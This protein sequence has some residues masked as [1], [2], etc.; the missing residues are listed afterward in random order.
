MTIKRATTAL[1]AVT[2]LAHPA[3][4]ETVLTFTTYEPETYSVI[5]C[6]GWFMEEV[7]KRTDGEVTFETFYSA[8]L[9]GPADT[10]PGVGRGAADIGMSYP[11]AYNRAEYPLSN[12]V[13][14]YVTANP[15]AATLAYNDLLQ[16]NEAFQEEYARG[17]TKILYSTV[18]IGHSLWSRDPIRT[19]DDV[20]G[21]R[22]RAVLAVGDALDKMGATVVALPFADAIQAMNNGAIDAMG[23]TPFD[24]A[25]TAGIHQVSNYATDLGGMGVYAASATGINLD[26][27]NG[28]APEIQQTMLEV[29]SEVPNECWRNVVEEDAQE[30][31]DTVVADGSVEVILFSEEEARELKETIG[32]EL[33]QE[34]VDWV[35]SEG[36]E[37]EAI[38]ARFEELIAKYEKESDF[39]NSFQRYLETKGN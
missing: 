38:L 39:K 1:A 2:A 28:L 17:N 31:V 6:D 21:K 5:A 27:W 7:T 16:E 35:T 25:V 4:A 13:M 8:V 9:L 29:A 32:A 12:I 10:F 19:A 11:S 24:L 34:W 15:I 36:Y 30:A 23:G 33:R 26:V 20:K 37:G 14:P 3:Q 22:T 18:T